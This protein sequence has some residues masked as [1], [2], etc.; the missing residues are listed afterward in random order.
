MLRRCF[1]T[2]APRTLRTLTHPV[3]DGKAKYMS[4]ENAI[5]LI[6]N[7]NICYPSNFAGTP[8]ELLKEICRQVDQGRLQKV[9]IVSTMV[10]GGAPWDDPKFYGKITSNTMFAT[11]SNR[12]L[13]QSGHGDY[14]P[15]FL[16]EIAKLFRDFRQ[17]LDVALT[18]IS[19]PDEH[20]NCSLGIAADC[21]FDAI[22]AAKIIIAE[23]IPSMPR[24]FGDT[25]VHISHFDA[26]VKTDRMLYA[27]PDPQEGNID[28]NASKIGKMIAENLIEDESTLQ[29]AEQIPSMPRTFGDTQVHISHFDAVV[30][31]DRML[32]AAPDPQEGNID[33]NASK[34]GKMIAENL[35]EDESTLQIGIGAITD[36][37]CTY[38][39]NHKNLGVHT[40]LLSDGMANLVKQNVI[41]NACKT[42]DQGR[43]VTALAYGTR[44]FYDYI[45]NNPIFRIG[46]I[47]DAA[48]TYLRNHKNL[49]VHT[50]L[51]SDGMANLVKQNVITNAC[52]TVD[53]GR[54]VTALA[55]GTR[56]FY[57]YI[58]NNPIFLFRSAAYTN[59][60][61]IIQKNHKMVSINACIE[62]DLTGQIAADSIGTRIY[63]GIGGQL[64]Y[65][66]GA[67][68]APG[69]KAIMALTSCTGKGDSKIVP[70]LKQGAGVVTTRGHVQY[71]VTEYGIAQLWVLI[72]DTRLVCADR[73]DN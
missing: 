65:V 7:G 52:K 20:G 45:N 48:C 36:A 44:G 19:P 21:S 25:Q 39:R 17:P 50:E 57:D 28:E 8:G 10:E 6:Q 18:T 73:S 34:I 2:A 31:T 38:L 37:A 4:L 54:C 60:P 3:G 41:T 63:S 14:T 51:L 53:Q 69:G 49:G 59:D 35:I 26:V 55:Y 72:Q 62:I 32:Y 27:A 30:K 12:K 13:V 47:T 5:K 64:D 56:G 33:E 58:N 66:Y 61:S 1:S 40:E 23:Q 22:R 71:I 29:I 68:S 43:C 67:A 11:N 42:V 15:M 9:H 70:F 16:S 46:A 24:T